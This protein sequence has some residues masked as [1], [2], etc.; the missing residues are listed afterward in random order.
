M[1]STMSRKLPAL[2]AESQR[3]W[4][5]GAEHRLFIHRCQPCQRFFHPPA[6]VCPHCLSEEVAATA[7][8]GRG[9]VAT[10]TINHQ[11]WTPQLDLPYV[12]AIIELDEQPGL[13]LVSNVINCEPAKVRIGMRVEV[14][15]LQQEDIW[16]PLFVEERS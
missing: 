5:G 2:T 12:I 13:R 14:E 11:A 6:P 16:L 9:Q 3:F 4:Q 8:S 15:F 1:E 7:V 10:F